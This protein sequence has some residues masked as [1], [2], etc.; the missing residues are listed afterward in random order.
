[1]GR[2]PNRR[3]WRRFFY[4]QDVRYVARGRK[5][6][7]TMHWMCR[8]AQVVCRERQDAG[9]DDAQGVRYTR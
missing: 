3:Q 8:A 4:A 6:V 9:S 7:A 2:K 1:M 5:P